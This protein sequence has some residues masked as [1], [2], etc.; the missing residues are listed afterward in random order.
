[1]SREGWPPPQ[2]PGPGGVHQSP[3]QPSGPASR[4]MPSFGSAQSSQN[5]PQQPG[6][7][8]PPPSAP[9]FASSN[10]QSG[11]NLPT[12]QGL[13]QP[14]PGLSSRPPP[15]PNTEGLQGP[16][17]PTQ[18]Q[19]GG[20]GPGYALPNINEAVQGRPQG[21]A[22]FERERDMRD[23]RR[24]WDRQYQDEREQEQQR[25]REA[26]ERQPQEPGP[27]HQTHAGSIPLHQPHAV[28]P[29]LRS[30]IHGPNGLLASVG[31]GPAP[32]PSP[33][34]QAPTN[35]GAPSG[36][37]NTFGGGPV[38]QAD[39]P[40]RM[41][42]TQSQQQALMPFAPGPGAQ[43]GAA[44]MGQGQQPI[45][46]DALSYLDQ[47]KVQFVDSPDVYNR[48]LDIMK[49]FKSG[50]IDTPGVIERVSTLFAGN[51]NLIQGFNT[52]LPPGYRIECGMGDDPNSIRVTTPMGTT[53]SSL[54]AP[55]PL[56]PR[57]LPAASA[58]GGDIPYDAVNRGAAT[59]WPQQPEGGAPGMA[60]S[61][62]GRV[63][64]PSFMQPGP[65]QQ[66]PIDTREQQLAANSAALAHQ[67]E[68]RG[69]SQL[70]NAVSAAAGGSLGGPGIQRLSPSGRAVT[71]QPQNING[72]G[73]DGQSGAGFE[74]R[75][76]V[77]FN[78]AISY[79]NKIKNRFASQPDT[80]KQF[81]EI[82]QTYQRESKPIQDV[83]A[84]VTHLF[85][86]APD[87]LEDFKQFLPESAAH[88]RAQAARQAAGGVMAE[89]VTM[90][91][92]LREPVYGAGQQPQMHQTPRIEQTKLPPMGN[93]APTPTASKDNKRK[94]GA[95]RQQPAV[96]S[97]GMGAL[98][99]TG[100]SV[101]N[102][103]GPSSAGNANKRTKY[104]HGGKLPE[105]RDVL[106]VSP[107]LVPALP[108]PL[109]PTTSSTA[110]QEELG[111]F[112]KVKK[113]IGNKNT[114]SE[115]LKLCNLFSQDLLSKN[116]LASR[117]H[118]YIGGN[119]ELMAYFKGFLKCEEQDTIIENKPRITLDRPSLPNCRGLTPSYRLLPK[120]AQPRDARKA[121]E[122]RKRDSSPAP[123][124]PNKRAA[125]SCGA[126]L[127][128]LDFPESN[129]RSYTA[130]AVSDKLEGPGMQ[131]SRGAAW[132]DIIL[133]G[134]RV[135]LH[136][137]FKKEI[138]DRV[139]RQRESANNAPAEWPL[140]KFHRV[141]QGDPQL[142][143]S[144]NDYT[145]IQSALDILQSIDS[146]ESADNWCLS[147]YQ[148]KMKVCS[149]RD[150]LCHSVLNDEWASHPTWASE[151]SGFVAHRKN[152]YEELLHRI[153]EERHDY[154]FNVEALARTVQLLLPYA[155]Q[156]RNMT[157][158]ERKAMRLPETLGGQSRTIHKRVIKKMYGRDT[159]E[160]V[161]RGLLDEPGDVVPL[162]LLRL[163]GKLEEWKASQ[164]G[165]KLPLRHWLNADLEL[166]QREW[167]KTWREQ[168]N[169]AF[170]K[171]L[172]HQNFLAKHSDKRQ[173]QMK[174]LQQ[175]I[176]SRWEEQQ[177]ARQPLFTS[178]PPFQFEFTHDDIDVI[179][180][181]SGLL[182]TY[183][184]YNHSTDVPR[185]VSFIKELL[186]L[187]FGF[188]PG[189]FQQ[190]IQGRFSS[191]GDDEL[192]E[193]S[194]TP[195]DVFVRSR[196]VNGK[197]DD[198]RRGVLERGRSGRPAR[199]D[200]EDSIVASSRDTT[201]EG[202]SAADDDM[203]G[204]AEL[205]EPK[206]E[207]AEDAAPEKWVE[208]PVEGNTFHM[209]N[210][211]PD[212]PYL[213]KVYHLYANVPIYCFFSMFFKLYERLKRLKDS[214]AA[215]HQTID[216]AM[217][218]KS[219]V[220]LKMVEKQPTDYFY[221][222]GPTCNYYSQMLRMMS[223]AVQQEIEMSQVEDTLRRYYLSSGYQLY[224]LDKLLSA[225]TR[226]AIG[227][228]TNEAKD[229]SWDIIQLFKKDRTH[230]QTTHQD[231]INYRKQVEKYCK[232]SDIYRFT[233]TEMRTEIQIFKKEDATFDIDSMTAANRWTYYISSFT[234][235]APTEG[236]SPNQTRLSVLRRALPN[237]PGDAIM[238]NGDSM[239]DDPDKSP[240][241]AFTSKNEL[242]D[243]MTTMKSKEGMQMR[244]CT[245]TYVAL[246]APNTEDM[247]YQ[248][249]TFVP[250]P[251]V[252]P[253]T[254]TADPTEGTS[255]AE[256]KEAT[257]RAGHGEGEDGDGEGGET[258]KGKE[259]TKERLVM[260]N[261]W[262]KG[263][264]KEQ[265]D[266]SND[267]H[268]QW[269]AEP[270]PVAEGEDAEMMDA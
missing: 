167:N 228:M 241:G 111:Y 177:R 140:Q 44:G 46:N 93:F 243:R 157:E 265:V 94:R 213:R 267:G 114:F 158:P 216:R 119:T 103:G 145:Q 240:S 5:N 190:S 226:F 266:A 51:P 30:V 198:L 237:I 52:F 38:Q 40:Q 183:A 117:A 231:E 67:Q 105:Q 4:P 264:S 90:L 79:V 201:P 156:L 172:D 82:L 31:P 214:E 66:S 166:S 202:A 171:S 150:E 11:H 225:L 123:E 110:S 233:F 269:K 42:M 77:E 138:A 112:E 218:Y 64:G 205:P 246:F 98:A 2:A 55:R 164:V 133:A 60:M 80:Y 263:I 144:G 170:Y 62:N 180:D 115:F 29:Q 235:V 134:P 234:N 209:R 3:E 54:P 159:G 239:G 128:D 74:K 61:P 12:L 189:K 84:Q 249:H 7:V 176:A 10:Q 248:H 179:L 182:L 102:R 126:D 268:R 199:R 120:R 100:P 69:V 33:A 91:S 220:D 13:P 49:D 34:A 270:A 83:Y 19:Q 130:G 262:M 146:R 124:H 23:Q 88:A 149:G 195:E 152:Q 65:S 155:Q 9:I 87:L 142:Q 139:K 92:N 43:A 71:P 99:D 70:Q 160:A 252:H 227:I 200:K 212:E 127:M 125:P 135:D 222:V 15:P 169:K 161:C 257:D 191:T 32:G 194:S 215:V 86:S 27:Q 53:V 26:R 219:A 221:E 232:E 107:T 260:N 204:G 185:L 258:E 106:N 25:E 208:H 147:H 58:A 20:Q 122:K 255:K 153:E 28:A 141:H 18:P 175:E 186:P 57:G 242:A 211:R 187:Y 75:G 196:K 72:V 253:T 14:S 17:H 118:A 244:I 45:L 193:D 137:Q 24:V 73:P 6:P 236:V 178:L 63:L 207:L 210:L 206:P 247:S 95:D 36:P 21:P 162:L 96:S 89:D 48:F 121:G 184:E 203:A 59:S 173:F 151:D 197:K 109:P 108:E 245:N 256:E 76:P 97:S 254:E 131:M 50:A 113:Y 143:T 223:E 174:T 78:H 39:G 188:D 22:E 238:N 136:K 192:D 104:Q 101:A 250:R 41:Q 168:T 217:E 163:Q 148:E 251:T 16:Q 129:G 37:G 8:L 261:A 165:H 1:M 85:N 47:V 132:A 56:S 224:Q 154:D 181:T 35:L 259:V 230:E 68:Q 116:E 229:K 81:L